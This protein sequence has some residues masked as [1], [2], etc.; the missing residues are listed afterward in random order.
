MKPVKFASV[1][2]AGGYHPRPCGIR[3]EKFRV[4]NTENKW[5]KSHGGNFRAGRARSSAKR[6]SFCFRERAVKIPRP[7][8]VLIPNAASPSFRIAPVGD[9][10]AYQPGTEDFILF[11]FWSNR[12]QTQSPVLYGYRLVLPTYAG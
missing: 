6:G 9:R 5:F 4:S 10:T 11:W 3:I 2:D 7:Y 8:P 1:T 12:Y